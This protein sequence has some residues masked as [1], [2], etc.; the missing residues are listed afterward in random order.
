MR[1]G[2]DRSATVILVTDRWVSPIAAI[3]KIMLPVEIEHPPFDPLIAPIALSEVLTERVRHHL[4]HEQDAR[5]KELYRVYEAV[6]ALP[7]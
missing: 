2:H 4:G 5:I 1:L 7:Q 3:S 6:G